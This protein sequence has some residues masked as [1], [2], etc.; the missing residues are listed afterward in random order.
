MPEPL[1]SE[2]EF[3]DPEPVDLTVPVGEV[4]HA[5]LVDAFCDVDADDPDAPWS[6]FADAALLTIG[7]YLL[8]SVRLA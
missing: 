3:V 7:G 2:P 5:L 1:S 8:G 6:D 4:L